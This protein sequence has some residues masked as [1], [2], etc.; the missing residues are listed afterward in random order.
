LGSDVTIAQSAKRAAKWTRRAKA[1][2]TLALSVD[3]MEK[4]FVCHKINM[5]NL[6]GFVCKEKFRQSP[7]STLLMGWSTIFARTKCFAPMFQN[8]EGFRFFL[9]N[10]G[11][12]ANVAKSGGLQIFRQLW[13]YPPIP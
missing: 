12:Y 10:F 1:L 9:C 7:E 8:P 3:I 6:K 11:V 2:R 13:R 5:L 4:Q